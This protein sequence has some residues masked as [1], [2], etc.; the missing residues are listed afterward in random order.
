MTA[1]N[2]VKPITRSAFI[3]DLGADNLP[4]VL[5]AAGLLIGVIMSAYAWLLGRLPRRWG[6]PITQV[7]W[8][9]S[10][11]LLAS[12]PER[13]PRWVSVAF[14]LRRASCSASC[15]SAS[16]GRWPT[17]LRSRD[18]PSGSSASSAAARRLGGMAGS[19][20]TH[21]GGRDRH[22]QPAARQRRRLL[23]CDGVVTLIVGREQTD[24][25]AGDLADARAGRRRRPRRSGCSKFAATADH[26]ARDR[27]RARSPAALIEHAAQHGRGGPR[28]RQRDAITSLLGTGGALMS[29]IA[30]RRAGH[31]DQPRASLPGPRLRAAVLPVGLGPRPSSF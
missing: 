4:Y 2:A 10:S 13:A 6:L 19:A 5:L 16:S 25:G 22:L 23:A 11:A 1:Y 27:V 18:R 9:R 8:P 3:K 21:R 14:Y 30:L 7:L 24:I 31:A 28:T 20:L 15:S 26:H 29:L 12:L 17:T